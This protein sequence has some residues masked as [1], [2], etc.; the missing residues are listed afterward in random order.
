MSCQHNSNNGGGASCSDCLRVCVGD[1]CTVLAGHSSSRSP[2]RTRTPAHTTLATF[3]GD[4]YLKK[5]ENKNG[6][7][8]YAARIACL[9]VCD[10]LKHI[11]C[12]CPEDS[13]PEGAKY[14]LSQ[15]SWVSFQTQYLPESQYPGLHQITVQPKSRAWISQTCPGILQP[16]VA[17]GRNIL[18][19]W[20][21]PSPP[22]A[23]D[24]GFWLQRV[25]VDHKHKNTPYELPDTTDL[26]LALAQCRTTL[27]LA[28]VECSQPEQ[29]TSVVSSDI[30]SKNRIA[31][32]GKK[33]GRRIKSANIQSSLPDFI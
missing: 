17:D 29:N 7:S 20:Y 25:D 16:L 18:K 9:T 33:Q 6:F 31:R 24:V 12:I 22:G 14:R 5:T 13:A 26:A 8:I 27:I 3:Y 30:D 19:T 11:L 1:H 2:T 32:L 28:G 15:L 21:R 4:P 23:T 10:G